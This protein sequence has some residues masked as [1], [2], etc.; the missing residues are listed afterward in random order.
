MCAAAVASAS[1]VEVSPDE[2]REA[3]AGWAALQEALAGG[4]RFGASAITGVKTCSGADGKG[5]FYVITFEGGGYAIASGDTE[6][7]PILGYSAEGEWVDD[8]TRNPLLVMLKLDVAAMSEAQNGAA[9]SGARKLLSAASA[10]SESPAA[11]RWAKLR[12][13][14]NAASARPRLLAS[15]VTTVTDEQISSADLRVGELL[16]TRW[17]QGSVGGRNCYNA[18]T[19]LNSA[20]GCVA[21]MAAQMMRYHRW[22]QREVT[23]GKTNRLGDARWSYGRT[24]RQSDGTTDGCWEVWANEL[25]DANGLYRSGGFQINGYQSTVEA[26]QAGKRKSDYTPWEPAFGGTYDW[27]KMPAVPSGSSSDEELL[28]IGRLCRDAGLT[29][30][31]A[32]IGSG[33]GAP[34][35]APL[36]LSLVDTFGYA[37]AKFKNAPGADDIR[38]GILACLDAKLPV[39]VAV[40]GHAIVADGYGFAGD[41]GDMTLYIHFNFGWGG[42]GS[43]YRP[44]VV[45]DGASLGGS[46]NKYDSINQILYNVY[47]E[48]DEGASIVSGRVLDK[49]GNP[50]AGVAVSAGAEASCA[51]DNHGIY[52]LFLSPGE[53]SV[54]VVSGSTV[55]TTNLTVVATTNPTKIYNDGNFSTGGSFVGNVW[56]VDLKLVEASETALGWINETAGTTGETGEWSGGIVY[57]Q[58]TKKATL[59]GENVFT[60]LP[61]GGNTATLEFTARF[62]AVTD[63]PAD[64]DS[65]A[66]MALCIGSNGKFR[67]WS[68]GGWVDVSADGITP[69]EEVEYTVRIVFDYRTGRYS[70]SVSVPGGNFIPLIDGA[71]SAGF[72]ISSDADAVGRVIMRGDCVFASLVGTYCTISGFAP[73]DITGEDA[74]ITLTEAQAAWLNALAEDKGYVTVSNGVASLSAARFEKAFLC[75]LDVTRGDFDATLGVTGI[76]VDEEKVAVEVTLRRTGAVQDG[77]RDAPING[78][79]RFYGAATVEAFRAAL[80]TMTPIADVAVDNADFGG[81][82]KATVEIGRTPDSDDRFF[83]VKIGEK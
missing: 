73:G 18:C 40:P 62:D 78:V 21:T 27:D 50:L 34:G 39:G 35:L 17:A 20:C 75:N 4:A 60:P 69:S 47:P 42:G 15:T 7:E 67:V 83:K 61:S 64:M 59:S 51:T 77:G 58:E 76:A 33:G 13:A 56:G 23:F 26:A 68:G 43:W 30:H 36:A 80:A 14:A 1:A 44:P 19:P 57:D 29:A 53:H 25:L 45:Y 37:D 71:G 52:A 65:D 63:D 2:A 66:Q 8:E 6:T 32:Y 72:A 55:A 31:M 9:R 79:L 81:G 5:V 38:N 82:D 46:D 48:G 10:V 41:E 70:A 49:D 22:P 11:K 28:E 24:V 54:R 3:V 16:E 12:R 74:E